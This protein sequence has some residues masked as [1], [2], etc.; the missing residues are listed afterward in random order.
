VSGRAK[1][2]IGK[3]RQEWVEWH[4]TQGHTVGGS[5]W[6]CTQESG[7]PARGKVTLDGDWR[8]VLERRPLFSKIGAL[9]HWAD[10][11]K[12]RQVQGEHFVFS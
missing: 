3:K 2:R 9:L 7:Y 4:R 8:P 10:S 12:L 5:H 6:W 1:A 11:R